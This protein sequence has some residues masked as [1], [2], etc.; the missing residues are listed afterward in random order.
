MEDQLGSWW[1]SCNVEGP[2]DVVI[3]KKLRFVKHNLKVWSKQQNHLNQGR[4]VWLEN[5]LKELIALEECG[6]SSE[7][8]WAEMGK[9]KQ[10]HKELLLREEISWRQRS[11]VRWLKE[12]D[13]NSAFFHA[14][15]SVRRR[16]N[17]IESLSVNGLRRNTK[18]DV[19]SA[20]V[21]F[22]TKLYASEGSLRPI[23]EGVEFNS[24]NLE[25][26]SSLEQPFSEEEI[27]KGLFSIPKDKAPGPD[28]FCLAFFQSC[29]SVVK[30]DI[31]RFFK[32]FFEDTQSAF[33]SKRQILDCSLIAN[34]VIDSYSRSGF[35]G[36]LCK[37]DMEKA[38]DRVDWECLDYLLGRMGFGNRWRSWMRQC[39]SSAW[40]SVLKSSLFA[41]NI[42]SSE[43]IDFADVM[44]CRLETFP[45]SYLGLPLGVG[46]PRKEIWNPIVEKI[47]RSCPISVILKIEM[48]QRRFLWGGSSSKGGIPLVNWDKVCIPIKSGGMGIRRLKEFNRALLGKWLW[49]FGV[50]QSAL[51]VKVVGSKYGLLQGSWCSDDKYGKKGR[52]IWRNILRL[53]QNFEA[54]IRFKV[55][56]GDR[57]KF[58]SDSWCSSDPLAVL[59]PGLFSVASIKDVK[60]AD[61]FE[62][63]HNRIIWFP[64]FRRNFFEQE[65]ADISQLLHLIEGCYIKKSGVDKRIWIW[66]PSGVFSVKSFYYRLLPV[67]G[68]PSFAAV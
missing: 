56:S 55:Y 9:A 25:A 37:L 60:V 61:C 64:S 14:M 43:A 53:K 15:A 52:T 8:D 57:I 45:S 36:V 65:L 44:G 5:R 47:E 41:I 1:S 46:R 11:R 22:Y 32:E 67:A 34:E 19:S 58:W 4:K 17:R 18:E 3:G 31:F 68:S 13:K 20:I 2:T 38:Y 50:E 6:L 62:R 24:L 27:E 54:G 7:V 12:G 66:N 26:S 59:F 63:I 39:I 48:L 23:P 35:G 29:W 51:W 30:R 40:F 28:G 42:P 49:Q 21:D 33:V 16:T 10:E